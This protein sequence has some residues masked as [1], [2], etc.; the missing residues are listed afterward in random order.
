ML[1]MRSLLSFHWEPCLIH[2]CFFL[3]P[4][5]VSTRWQIFIMFVHLTNILFVIQQRFSLSRVTSVLDG[6][7]VN[8]LDK[9]QIC[10]KQT[11]VD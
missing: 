2:L 5:P 10:E 11:L 8:R 7:Q 1:Q 9:E 6:T 4:N 3:G